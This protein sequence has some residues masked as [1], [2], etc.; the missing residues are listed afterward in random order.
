MTIQIQPLHRFNACLQV[1]GDKSISHRALLLGA[2]AEGTTRITGLLQSADIA[3]TWHCLEQLGV[4][5]ERQE[6]AV[7]VSGVGLEGLQAPC[8]TLD[9]GNSA[10]TLRLLM[11]ILAGQPF[12][13]RLCGDASLSRRPMQRVAVPLRA[14]G[15]KIHLTAENYPPVS[16]EPACLQGLDYALPIASAQLKGALLLAGLW[17]QGPLTLRGQIGSRDHSERLLKHFGVKLVQQEDCL[18]LWPGQRLR[19]NSMTIPGDLSAAAFWL[20]AAALI[21]SGRVEICGVSLNPTRLGFVRVLARMGAAIALDTEMSEPEP[22]GRIRLQQ[23]PLQA[24]RILPHEIPDLIDEIPLIALL[25]TQAHGLTE[26][27][28]A[29]E[30]RVKESDRLAA[31]ACNLHAMGVHMDLFEDGFALEGPQPLYGAAINPFGDHR[32]AMTFAIAGLIAQG[33]TLIHNPHCVAISYPE[34]FQVL[35]QL[36]HGVCVPCAF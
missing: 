4:R 1:P 2:L 8:Q 16:L 3:S 18:Q 36:Q 29:A 13:S 35:A 12:P 27:R 6:E 30:L 17:A 5:I 15:A 33:S 21:P 22:M 32:M 11:G 9:C 10:T 7:L 28:G 20:T 34:F 26:V 19:A 23:M 31:L 14:M 25:A 24:T